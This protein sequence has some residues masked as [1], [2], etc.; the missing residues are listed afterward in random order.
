MG[1]VADD[2]LRGVARFRCGPGFACVLAYA[3]IAGPAPPRAATSGSVLKIE[4]SPASRVLYFEES[5]GLITPVAKPMPGGDRES[6]APLL[7]RSTK[8]LTPVSPIA[9]AGHARAG[10]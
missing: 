6:P 7:K 10:R 4:E 1:S 3:A 5:G 9:R 8:A 2:A